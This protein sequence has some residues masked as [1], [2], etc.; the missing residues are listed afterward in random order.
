MKKKYFLNISINYIKPNN[1]SVLVFQSYK[2]IIAIYDYETKQLY[3]NWVY[4]D[5]SKT[6]MKHLKIF[7]NKYT[8]FSYE[9]KQQFLKE[10]N[11]NSL[12]TTF[13]D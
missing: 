3:I 10:I 8:Y 9:N 4:W 1:F 7:I 13:K 12:I 11:N 5:Y 6:T 2:T